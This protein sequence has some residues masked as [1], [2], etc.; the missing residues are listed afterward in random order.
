MHSQSDVERR[1]KAIFDAAVDGIISINQRGIIEEVNLASCRLFGYTPEE[2]MGKNVS[3]LMPIEHSIH[4]DKYLERYH[5]TRQAKI[6]GIGREV[7]GKKKNGEEFPFW[8]AVIEVKLDQS[9][10]YTGFIHDLSEIKN[11]EDRLKS[12][13]EDLEKKVMDRT[14]ELENAVNQLLALNRQFEDEIALKIKVQ[15]DL[16]EREAELE[17]SLVKEKELGELKSRFVSMASHEFRTPLATILSS[18][19]LIGRYK[20][21]DQQA[22]RDK[23]I[24][25]IKS[26]VSHLTGIL[27]DFLSMNKLEEGKI[28]TT[29]GEFDAKE[30]G[31]EVVEEFKTI[32]KGQQQII[33][34][35]IGQSEMVSSDRKILK[36][37]L[38][39][40]LSN[41]IKYTAESGII[42]VNMWSNK[43]TIR[44]SIADNGI[45]IPEDEQKHLFDRFFRASNAT[46]IEGTGLGLNIVKKYAEML[47]GQITFQSKLYEGSTFTVELP[48]K[49][50]DLTQH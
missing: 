49:I 39:N 23:H 41:A 50:A 43:D 17:K 42:H 37:I 1:L 25:K 5:K 4:H 32:L 10:I 44:F 7:V 38:I 13:N 27:N 2:M 18:V 14:Y 29:I 3:F 24:H 47:D 26:S 30:I 35:H 22:N 20:E 34:D 46:N 36:N 11:A 31:L 8:L 21:T 33:F 6:I 16:K 28:M 40:L 19:S 12:L 15:N 48:N 45:G 9:T